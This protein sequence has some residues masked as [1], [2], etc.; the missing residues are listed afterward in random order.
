MERLEVGDFVF[1][2]DSNIREQAVQ[3]YEVSLYGE[4]N[5]GNLLL[6]I[7]SFLSLEMGTKIC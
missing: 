4:Q 1:S 5:L 3:Y 6:M 2:S 7:C